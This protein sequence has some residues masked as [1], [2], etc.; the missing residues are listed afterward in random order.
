MIEALGWDRK[1]W[2]GEVRKGRRLDLVYSLRASNFRGEEKYSL[3]LEAL[4]AS[5][6]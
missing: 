2:L 6:K 5:E 4:K 3:T 1:E